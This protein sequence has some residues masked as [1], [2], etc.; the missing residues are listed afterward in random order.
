MLHKRGYGITQEEQDLLWNDYETEYFGKKQ[1][2]IKYIH[3]NSGGPLVRDALSQVYRKVDN[4]NEVLMVRFMD[5]KGTSKISNDDIKNIIQLNIG[6]DFTNYISNKILLIVA[7]DLSP[8]A[9]A[10]VKE[11]KVIADIEVIHEK[12]LL[13]DPTAHILDSKYIKLSLEERASFYRD[14][15]LNP[16][17]IPQFL[18]DDPIVTAHGWLPGDLIRVF[19]RNTFTNGLA[20]NSIMYR[21]VTTNSIKK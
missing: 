1:E 21:V 2:F 14:N 17:K 3:V 19:R 13:I 15:K 20:E 16:S 9:K 7:A 18:V 10:T 6:P 8:A 4:P 11:A 5:V 12:Y